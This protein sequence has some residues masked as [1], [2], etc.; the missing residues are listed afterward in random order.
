MTRFKDC[1]EHHIVGT[2]L[3]MGVSFGLF[4]L[5]SFNLVYLF[6]ANLTLFL[7]Y[8]VMVIGDGALQ[9]LVEL[10]GYGYLGLGAYVI[11]KICEHALVARALMGHPHEFRD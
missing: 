3:L 4:G 10:I 1:L 5:A 6:K 2:F 8:G 7:D 11:F 9:Q